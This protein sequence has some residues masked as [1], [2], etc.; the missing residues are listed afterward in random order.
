[1]RIAF[2]VLFI[3]ALID[4]SPVVAGGQFG[5]SNN[6]NPNNYRCKSGKMVKRAKACKENGGQY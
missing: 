2:A 5:G 1:V 3:A 6:G 4:I